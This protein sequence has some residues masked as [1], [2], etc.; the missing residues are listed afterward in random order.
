MTQGGSPERDGEAVVG[1]G[2][3]YYEVGIAKFVALMQPI[4]RTYR[5]YIVGTICSDALMQCDA[6]FM[7][8]PK[9]AAVGR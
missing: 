9:K 2:Q 6:I 7:P 5:A 3:A 4:A 1:L 8:L